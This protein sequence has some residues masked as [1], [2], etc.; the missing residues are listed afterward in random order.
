VTI[1][2]AGADELE[3]V[4]SLFREYGDSLGVDLSFQDFETELAELPWEYASILLGLV[5]GRPCGCVAVRPL[6]GGACEMKRLFVRPDARG[7]GLGRALAEAAIERARALGFVRMRLDTL[8]SMEAAR[9]LYRS[10]GFAEIDPYRFN[11]IE[12]TTFME[13]R[14][15]P[16]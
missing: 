8:P 6:E 4:R 15:R 7:T 9:A 5:D 13:L 12:G 3:L 16:I 1:A 14:L 10:L 11:P 2:E